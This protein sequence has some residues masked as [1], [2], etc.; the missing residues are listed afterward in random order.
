MLEMLKQNSVST[1]NPCLLFRISSVSYTCILLT[2]ATTETTIDLDIEAE[3]DT[4][5]QTQTN[6][7]QKQT[8]TTETIIAE[9]ESGML[10]ETEDDIESESES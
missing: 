6:E 10:S 3:T 7:L 4:N 1:L 2:R 9:K 5:S 8:I